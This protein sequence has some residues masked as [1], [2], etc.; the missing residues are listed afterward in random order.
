MK[1]EKGFILVNALVLVAALSAVAVFLL[2]RAEQGRVQ[3]QGG[4]EAAQLG[5]GLDAFEALSI[6]TL[7]RDRG[8]PRD[9]LR[10]AWA[11]P[12]LNLALEGGVLSGRIED[13]QGR[14]NLNWLADPENRLAQDAFDRLVVTLGQSPETGAALRLALQPGR[15]AN[16]AAFL[17]L[18]PPRDPVGGAVHMLEQL[19]SLPNVEASSWARLRPYVTALPGDSRLNVNTADAAVLAAFLPELTLPQVDQ[20]IQQRTQTPFASTEAFLQHVGLS[21]PEEENTEDTEANQLS[22]AHISVGS[23]W[24]GA[25]VSYQLGGLFAERDLLLERQGT[26]AGTVVAWRLTRLP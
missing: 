22:E 1:Q 10:E 11:R 13:M 14:F 8:D 5:L 23:N 25:S 26:A 24:F 4:L 15:P 2:A 18:D 3:L 20:L 6:A 17:H 21:T 7:E 19:A 16:A 9:H 12:S